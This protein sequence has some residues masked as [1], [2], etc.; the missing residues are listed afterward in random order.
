[1]RAESSKAIQPEAPVN[2]QFTE[3]L[4]VII[5]RHAAAASQVVQIGILAMPPRALR[6][7]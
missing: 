4:R 6:L 1:M 5:S 3:P 7:G 2:K